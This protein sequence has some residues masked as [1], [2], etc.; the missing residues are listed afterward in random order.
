MQLYIIRH[1]VRLS[2]VEVIIHEIQARKPFPL[3][4][5]SNHVWRLKDN[6]KQT[7]YMN[8]HVH[9]HIQFFKNFHFKLMLDGGTLPCS[10][11]LSASMPLFYITLVQLSRKEP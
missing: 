5:L 7:I 1:N 6:K 9:I 10:P 8:T 2:W 11:H 4:E 3:Q